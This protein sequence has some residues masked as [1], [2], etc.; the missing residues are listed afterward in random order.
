MKSFNIKYESYRN[1]DLSSEKLYRFR[2]EVDRDTYLDFLIEQELLSD[3]NA[4]IERVDDEINV[5]PT[6][7]K[8]AYFYGKSVEE[9]M[10]MKL[11]K[12]KQ[13]IMKSQEKFNL[14]KDRY[15]QAY[16]DNN[17]KDVISLEYNNGY[18]W[19]DTSDE[20]ITFKRK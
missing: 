6:N 16:R 7:D 8:W 10:F 20:K 4:E 3:E 11:P 17:G 19:L 1:G 18:I 13:S 14:L 9:I 2:K 15:I 12:K 5:Y